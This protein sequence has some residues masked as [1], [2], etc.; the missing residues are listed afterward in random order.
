VGK[1]SNVSPSFY[2]LTAFGS[3]SNLLFFIFSYSF[4]RVVDRFNNL[5][6]SAYVTPGG[7]YLLLLHDGRSEDAVRGF[8]TEIHELYTKYIL[9]P[10]AILD[11]PIVS[12]QFDSHVRIASRRFFSL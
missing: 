10:F 7:V 5:A 2:L 3:H 1:S 11:G 8:F 9:N 4:L 6:V 12:P